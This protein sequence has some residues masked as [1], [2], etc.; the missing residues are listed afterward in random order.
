M[1]TLDSNKFGL[2]EMNSNELAEVEGGFYWAIAAAFVLSA[3]NNWG[4][5]REGWEDGASG[6]AARH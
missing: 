4:D 5:I 2:I 3:M 1:D 6:G